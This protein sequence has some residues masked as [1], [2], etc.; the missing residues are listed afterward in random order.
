VA[1]YF[2]IDYFAPIIRYDSEL[3]WT[4][5]TGGADN[6]AGHLHSDIAFENVQQ[7]EV[8]LLGGPRQVD[9]LIVQGGVAGARSHGLA[10][11]YWTWGIFILPIIIFFFCILLWLV[12]GLTT[13]LAK[14]VRQWGESVCW[15]LPG[16]LGLVMIAADL[17][18]PGPLSDNPVC[19]TH[20][21]RVGALIVAAWGTIVQQLTSIAW[22]A[23]C[24]QI[25]PEY[26]LFPFKFPVL[27]L[28]ILPLF[29][30][31]E[32]HIAVTFGRTFAYWLIGLPFIFHLPKRYLYDQHNKAQAREKM[33]KD[34]D[35]YEEAWEA[36]GGLRGHERHIA[37]AG[38]A[39]G[40]CAASVIG[41]S[42]SNRI[43][44]GAVPVGD[45]DSLLERIRENCSRASASIKDERAEA[46]AKMPMVD[47]LLFRIGAGPRSWQHKSRYARTGKYRQRTRNVDKLFDE[48]AVLND[49]FLSMID[50]VV[51]SA[52]NSR[53]MI[54][55]PL[56][57]P[58]RALQK[59]M[60]KYFMDP[61]C[62]TDLVRGCVLLASIE[63]LD[64]CLEVI[65]D[66]SVIGSLGT[67][68]EE[69][70]TKN[71]Q[72]QPTPEAGKEIKNQ[73]LADLLAQKPDLRITRAELEGCMPHCNLDSLSFIKV[74]G[75]LLRPAAGQDKIFKL[76]KIKDRCTTFREQ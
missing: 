73:D 14:G 38:G 74:D 53:G 10:C 76:V 33:R 70:P 2:I 30:P 21:P 72:D 60:R 49:H 24:P 46:V 28:S 15:I 36:A 29:G 39:R 48:A 34:V 45:T 63:D 69:V 6:L 3:V 8:D 25:P 64:H 68:W 12:L 44:D 4:N 40:L 32:D 65:L 43:G 54:R 7:V 55:G 18:V 42:A 1:S 52:A 17:S 16:T 22:G 23:L 67:K 59:S 61:R 9:G 35:K 27:G 71:D 26:A 51:S 31:A 47:R 20:G 57:R 13:P 41:G 19:N 37:L 75:K 56:K 62:L 5:N 50:G 11:V 66:L 58:D